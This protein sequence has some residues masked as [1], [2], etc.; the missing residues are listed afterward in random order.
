MNLYRSMVK[1]LWFSIVYHLRLIGAVFISNP[2]KTHA[3]AMISLSLLR[4]GEHRH[5]LEG[6]RAPRRGRDEVKRTVGNGGFSEPTI[7]LTASM[8][9]GAIMPQMTCRENIFQGLCTIFFLFGEAGWTTDRVTIVQGVNPFI[10]R[11]RRGAHRAES[12]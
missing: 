11:M 4:R 10:G 6:R 1:G 2:S 3:V 12:S 8:K 7:R 9:R 5:L